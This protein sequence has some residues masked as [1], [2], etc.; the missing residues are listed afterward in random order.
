[1]VPAICASKLTYKWYKSQSKPHQKSD[2]LLFCYH[3]SK[4][5]KE[6]KI[7]LKCR[8]KR[9]RLSSHLKLHTKSTMNWDGILGGGV[10]Q[11]Q[12]TFRKLIILY[13]TWLFCFRI[14]RERNKT[15]SRQARVVVFYLGDLCR[16]KRLQVTD[17]WRKCE[18]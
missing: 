17:P 7:L 5:K 14:W 4:R 9:R 3:V 15:V 12:C 1:M 18:N 10:R 8:K 11:G 16:G 6:L 2:Y 13:W